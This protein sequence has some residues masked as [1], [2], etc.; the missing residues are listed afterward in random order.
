[1]HKFI[2]EI[3][4]EQLKSLLERAKD[5]IRIY[6]TSPNNDMKDVINDPK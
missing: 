6:K 3:S 4:E 1:M 5:K 2:E